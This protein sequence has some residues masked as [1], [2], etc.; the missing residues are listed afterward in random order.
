MNTVKNESKKILDAFR[1]NPDMV[2]IPH[3]RCDLDLKDLWLA[4]G[5]VRN[6]IWNLLSGQIAFDSGDG[7]GCDGFRC[8]L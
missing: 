1:G 7:C 6:F 5:S 3:D 8:F 2:T 4:A